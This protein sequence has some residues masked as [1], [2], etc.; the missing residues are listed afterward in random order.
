MS[1]YIKEWPLLV[2]CP[3]SA[4]YHWAS[5]CRK[6]LGRD[7]PI[8]ASTPGG[9]G[10]ENDDSDVKPQSQPPT[11]TSNLLLPDQVSVLTSSKD[12]VFPTNDTKVVVCS[13]GLVPIMVANGTISPGLFRC[14]IV[15]ESHMLKNKS[16]KRTLG[17]IPILR[18]TN[19]C[20]LLSG[21]PALSR[22]G[23]LWPQL[24]IIGLN[25]DLWDTDEQ[26]F[27]ERYVKNDTAQRRAE[28][29]TLLTGTVMIR[30][31]KPDILKTLPHKLRQ[32]ATV[33]VLT[34]E[35]RSEFKQLLL[36]LRES[37]GALGKLARQEHA[38]SADGSDAGGASLGGGMAVASTI[39]KDEA[40]A[41][42]ESN[43]INRETL[44]RAFN[45]DI[46]ERFDV[47]RAQM[48]A[49]IQNSSYHLSPYDLED[50]RVRLEG[51]L[52]AKF[53]NMRREGLDRIANQYGSVSDPVPTQD[54][55]DGGS[56]RKSLLS[57]LYGLTGDVKAPLVVDLLDKW[58]NDRTKGKVCI[59]AHH[60]SVLDA[61][62]A[63]ADLSND[64][65][66][67]RKYIRIDGSTSPKFRQEQIDAFQNDPS[68]RVALLG[69]TAAGVAVTLTAS[70]TVWF[71][72]LFWT[73][74]L[75][76]QAEDRAHRIG[77]TSQVQCLYVVAKGT[78]DEYVLPTILFVVV[79]LPLTLS[80]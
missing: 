61:I 54:A 12:P 33:K 74:A 22:P 69:I 59:F 9:N 68:I 55:E 80:L 18:A 73:P 27:T 66:S 71:A 38:E 4:R 51:Q 53:E 7:S 58:F 43:K 70:S 13:Y 77:Q 6:W 63:G 40:A 36:D 15:D 17:L 11:D 35:H 25:P 67:T 29:H 45:E 10:S 2:L 28:L 23:E 50:T 79:L 41:R 30:R 42:A 60:L 31:L 24:E 3:S 37:K 72:E 48:T 46:R 76:I 21:T 75:M 16:A 49:L 20:V 19:Q 56:K 26:D 1:V 44:E 5:E 47:E 64:A 32:K 65:S 52:C 39:Q 14:A 34:D 62:N 57:R 8:N 78:L